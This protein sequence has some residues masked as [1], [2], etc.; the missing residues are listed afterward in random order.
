[1]SQLIRKL[2]DEGIR[3][4]GEYLASGAPGKPPHQLLTGPDTSEPLS[5]LIVVQTKIYADRFEFGR[6]LV[7]LLSPLDPAIVS[8][9]RH[10]WS[11]LA[12]FWFD[13]LCPQR[14]DGTR[15]VKE[16]HRYIYT[17][18]FRYYYRHL[19]RSPWYVVRHHGDSGRF[20]LMGTKPS[21][22]PLSVHGE[23]LEQIGGRQ[24]VF[25]SRSIVAAASRLY[26]D[27]STGR[28]RRGVAGRG[29]GSA[30]R[31]GMVLR[32]LDLTYDPEIMPSDGL[33]NILP[34][35]FDNW[36][37]KKTNIATSEKQSART[38]ELQAPT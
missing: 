21:E 37:E 31:F 25:G 8:A 13:Q 9:D 17:N 10:L 23:I 33:I 12:L 22:Y 2:T 38:T 20:L 14:A 5:K 34:A 35:E 32:Q 30:F 7:E 15:D 3:L 36:K 19:V 29:R 18:D 16:E 4:F 6:V 27:P 11:W 1:M 28:P 24:Q 26:A